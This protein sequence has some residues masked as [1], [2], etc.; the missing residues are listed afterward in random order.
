VGR[1]RGWIE[2][3]KGHFIVITEKIRFLFFNIDNHFH[4]PSLPHD[5]LWSTNDINFYGLLSSFFAEERH[6]MKIFRA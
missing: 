3:G 6:D 4:E 2:E 1:W 5:F